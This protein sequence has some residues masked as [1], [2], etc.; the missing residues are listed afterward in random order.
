[1][2]RGKLSNAKFEENCLT[3]YAE[4]FP[5]VCGDLTFYQFPSEQYWA[6]LFDAVPKNFIFGF[7]VPEDITVSVWPK[8]ARYGRRAGLQNENFLNAEVL[9]RCFTSRLEQYGDRVGTVE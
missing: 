5:S 9:Q 1:M 2:T 6:K 7:K 4:T 3:E 8:H